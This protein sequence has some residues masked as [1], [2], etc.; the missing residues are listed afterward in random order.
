MLSRQRGTDVLLAAGFGQRDVP[1]SACRTPG[2]V[3]RGTMHEHGIAEELIDAV[4]HVLSARPGCRAVRIRIAVDRSV[5][6]EGLREH[7]EA[8]ATDG[9]AA[10]AELVFDVALLEVTCVTCGRRSRL[11]SADERA[12]PWS[13]TALATPT[14][15][16]C[17]SGAVLAGPPAPTVLTSIEMET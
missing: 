1:G 17:G 15:P 7:F 14:C 11:E 4:G 3:A 9:P 8:L 12:D 6:T 5:A 13:P 2:K 10:G 16:A